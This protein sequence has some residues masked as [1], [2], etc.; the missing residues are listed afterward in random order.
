MMNA[1]QLLESML[2]GL[3]CTNVE[4]TGHASQFRFGDGVSYLNL[5]CAWRLLVNNAVALGAEDHEQRFGLPEP[6]DGV[7]ESER[8]LSSSFVATIEVREG[9]GDLGITFENGV[10][11]ES[12]N[13]SSGYEGWICSGRN[14]ARVVAQ[15]GENLVT[16]NPRE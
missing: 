5:Q 13:D 1:V 7:K 9:C 11:L 4:T 14:G 12:F 10:R 2:I 3:P 6:L 16:W 8:I 15:G